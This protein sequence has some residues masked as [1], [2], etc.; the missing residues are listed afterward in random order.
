MTDTLRPDA[1]FSAPQSQALFDE[2]KN[3]EISFTPEIPPFPWGKFIGFGLIDGAIVTSAALWAGGL[4]A[5]GGF[6]SVCGWALAILGG[7]SALTLLYRFTG[8]TMWAVGS[9][10]LK[11]MH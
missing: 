5:A 3:W 2:L 9:A 1:V 7:L 11:R 4:I 6:L 8:L 10:T